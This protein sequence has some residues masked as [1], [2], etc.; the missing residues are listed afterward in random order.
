MTACPLFCA[1]F[2]DLASVRAS[3][4]PCH[5]SRTASASICV[6]LRIVFF[7]EPRPGPGSQDAAL[8]A[9]PDEAFK[10]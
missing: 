8:G 10:R 3:N 2:V 5:E 9:L 7:K 1:G 4:P 6:N